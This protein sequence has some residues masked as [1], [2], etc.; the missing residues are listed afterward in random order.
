MRH[1]GGN[2]QMNFASCKWVVAAGLFIACCLGTEN[3]VYGQASPTGLLHPQRTTILSAGCTVSQLQLRFRTGND[4]LRGGQNNLDVEVHFADGTMQVADNV[5]H[6]ANWGNNSTNVV[7]VPLKQPVA[8]GQIKSIGLVHIAKG[9]FTPPT[10]GGVGALSTPAG[11]ALAP[12]YAAQGAK[13][14]DNWD[15]A[16]FQASAIGNNVSGVPV[17]SFGFHRFT[18]SAPDLLVPVRSDV[19]CPDPDQVNKLSFVFQ[20]GDDDLRGGNDNLNIVVR[21]AD[22]KTQLEKNVNQRA[23]WADGSAH[24]V[25]ITLNQPVPRVQIAGVILETTFSGGANGDNW[26]M[27]SVQIVAMTEKGS[28]FPIASSGFHRFS[29][30][31]TGPKARRLTIP[32]K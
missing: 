8:P 3:K 2:K 30:D 6:G 14:E 19:G 27:N 1:R 21:F 11:P 26:N 31:P 10:P 12:I 15:M 32:I 5:N 17:A 29:A 28:N 18:G 22:G 23:R 24:G 9:G 13:S 20:T 4:D 16:E 7:T 25:V